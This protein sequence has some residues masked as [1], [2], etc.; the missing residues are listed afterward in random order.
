MNHERPRPTYYG[1]KFDCLSSLPQSAQPVAAADIS[2]SP[3]S[4][5]P[6]GDSEVILSSCFSDCQFSDLCLHVNLAIDGEGSNNCGMPDI[7][8]EK[9]VGL[10]LGTDLSGCSQA[11]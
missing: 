1:Y 11:R 5:T 10:N 6:A 9:P 8:H 3:S 2:G 7:Y 4:N